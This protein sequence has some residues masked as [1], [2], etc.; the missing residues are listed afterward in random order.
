VVFIISS[1]GYVLYYIKANAYD[2]LQRQLL[3]QE[4]EQL[5]LYSGKKD[6]IRNVNRLT[7]QNIQEKQN[8]LDRLESELLKDHK[9]TITL[10]EALEILNRD[11]TDEK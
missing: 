6:S 7:L 4:L 2:K 11:N 8:I 3:D 10:E 1:A 5:E 9:D